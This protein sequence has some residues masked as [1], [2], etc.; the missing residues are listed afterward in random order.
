[1]HKSMLFSSYKLLGCTRYTKEYKKRCN[2]FGAETLDKAYIGCVVYVSSISLAHSCRNCNYTS[3]MWISKSKSPLG[4]LKLHKPRKYLVTP[5][6]LQRLT[7]KRKCHMKQQTQDKGWMREKP[8]IQKPE[9]NCRMLN[10]IVCEQ[11]VI[12]NE[13]L[14]G[15]W[16]GKYTTYLCWQKP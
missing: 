13:P 16:V 8:D 3:T 14:R 11:L 4:A 12:Q 10:Q 1:M 6:S 9:M 5:D 2:A 7:R 15:I